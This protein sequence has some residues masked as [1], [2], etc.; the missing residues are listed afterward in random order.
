MLILATIAVI[1]VLLLRSAMRN[2]EWTGFVVTELQLV[3]P[4]AIAWLVF[5]A[6]K[7]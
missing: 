4:L 6:R 7:P 5:G 2:G 3:V 1:S